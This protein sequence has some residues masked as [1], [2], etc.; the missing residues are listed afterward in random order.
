MQGYLGKFSR[1]ARLIGAEM[2]ELSPLLDGDGEKGAGDK[3]SDVDVVPESDPEDDETLQALVQ[4]YGD[5]EK[6]A[7][8]ID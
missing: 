7:A 2:A 5:G 1:A 3:L 8:G 6:Q 4:D